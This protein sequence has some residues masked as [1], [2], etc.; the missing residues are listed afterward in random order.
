VGEETG[1]VEGEEMSEGEEVVS[2]GQ[3]GVGE[4]YDG[5]QLVVAERSALQLEGVGSYGQ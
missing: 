1:G 5:P 2:G 3:L 4:S